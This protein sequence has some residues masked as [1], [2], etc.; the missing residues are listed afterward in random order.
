MSNAINRALRGFQW[1]EKITGKRLSNVK[2][3]IQG[4]TDDGTSA[5]VRLTN[6]ADVSS[7]EQAL[8]TCEKKSFNVRDKI[9]EKKSVGGGAECD[10]ESAVM[11]ADALIGTV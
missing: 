10:S 11:L 7:V 4:L 3:T 8:K 9:G 6:V 1:A 5:N 2:V